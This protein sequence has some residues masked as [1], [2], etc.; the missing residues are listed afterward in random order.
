MCL[1]KCKTGSVSENPFAVNVLTS[2]K[3]CWN[4]QKSTF[5]LLFHHSGTKLSLKKVFLIRS[6]IL[7]L[8]F[9]TLTGNY[10]YS[11]SDIENLLLQIQIKLCRKPLTILPSFFLSIGIYIKFPIFWSKNQRHRSN[12]SQFIDCERCAYLNA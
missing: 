12:I 2:S 3:N 11:H 6:E 1:F 7:G 9:N 5:I 4:L 8:L 10:E